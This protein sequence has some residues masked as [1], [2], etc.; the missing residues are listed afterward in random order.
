MSFLSIALKFLFQFGPAQPA[1]YILYK[2]GIS[3]GHYRRTERVNDCSPAL[4]PHSLFTLPSRRS[5]LAILNEPARAALLDEAD[6][7]VRD[8]FRIFGGEMVPL[9]LSFSEPLQH[10]TAYETGKARIP[11]CELPTDDLKFIWEPARFGWAFILGRAYYLSGEEKYAQAFWRHTDTFLENNPPYL[12]PHWMNGQEAALRLMA[13][14]WSA[15]IFATSPAATPERLSRLSRSIAD[16]ALRVEQTLMYARAQ[17]NNHLLSESAALYTAALALPEHPH[18]GRWRKR[19]WRWLNWALQHQIGSF[20]EY[21]QHSANYHRLMLHCALW[22]HAIKTEAWPRATFEPL[23]RAS[24]WLFSLLD[25]GSGQTPNLGA[26]DG[27]LILPLAVGSFHDYR[28]TVQAAARAFLRSSL[29]S[30]PWDEMGLWLNL[31]LPDKTLEP[32]AYL[33]DNLR[34]KESWAYLRTT[35]FKSRLGHMDHLH[36]DLWWRGLNVAQDAGT[37]SYNAPPPWNNPLA[38]SRVHNTVTVDGSDQ[39][40]RAGRF[41]VLDWFPSYSKIILEAD[42]NILQKMTGHYH[43]PRMKHERAVTVYA[44]ERWLVTDNVTA[45]DKSTHVFRLHWLLPDWKWELKED[46]EAAFCIHLQSPHGEIVLRLSAQASMLESHP[47]LTLLRAGETLLGSK[48]A[49]PFEGWV[50]PTYGH[51]IPA[52]SWALECTARQKMTFLSE[53]VFPT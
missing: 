37:Y 3:S 26:N 38:A 8:R 53:F 27:A 49:L 35:T 12:G 9:Q 19:G 17:N 46:G 14:V 4:V 50:S 32:S 1:L 44:D 48:P 41:M 51:K 23:Q 18:A 24:A 25:L 52:L 43:T 22:I 13:F 30:G 45:K 10:W 40:T 15:Q 31:P 34:G 47:N 28:P 6:E 16:H 11:S 33:T 7:I 2:L 36:L 39:M 5:L 42:E 20:G 29:P 21:I